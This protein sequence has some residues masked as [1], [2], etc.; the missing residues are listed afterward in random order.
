M[1]ER[2]S[3]EIAASVVSADPTGASADGKLDAAP[4]FFASI[5]SPID[6]I[7]FRR[8]LLPRE[9]ARGPADTAFSGVGFSGVVGEMD[10]IFGPSIF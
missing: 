9:Q 7:E 10:D 8:F 6:L 5:F 2:I 3:L 4:S 1:Y